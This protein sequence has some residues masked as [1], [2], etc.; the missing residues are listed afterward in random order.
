MRKLAIATLALGALATTFVTPA[1]AAEPTTPPDQTCSFTSVTDPSP[2]AGENAQFGYIDGGPILQNGTITCTIQVGGAFHSSAN[3]GASASATGTNG[4]TYLPPTLVSYSSPPLTPV[5]LCTQFTDTD[6]VTW[7]WDDI[8]GDW[9]TDPNS[10]CGLAISGGTSD[11]IFDPVF[12]L[13]DTIF[14]L[15]TQVEKDVIDPVVC[16]ALALLDDIVPDV[17]GVLEIQDDGDLYV[18]G[19]FIWDCPPYVE[20]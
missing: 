2:E 8:P 7:Y 15:L 17:A 18:A 10:D 14:D 6:N 11:P 5:Y 4:F 3:N 9:T 13:I 12:E 19:E 1:T 16:P 20:A